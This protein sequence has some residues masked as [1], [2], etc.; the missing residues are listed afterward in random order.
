MRV[1]TC[2]RGLKGNTL[3]TSGCGGRL[4]STSCGV[5]VAH[6][7]VV[8]G[9]VLLD[10]AGGEQLVVHALDETALLLVGDAP[11][12][13]LE[14]HLRHGRQRRRRQR[15]VG[16]VRVGFLDGAAEHGGIS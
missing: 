9:Q 11:G 6:G 3:D 14:R 4:A 8:L 10:R 1:T 2:S 12:D 15:D 5:Q 7:A 16:R 13:E